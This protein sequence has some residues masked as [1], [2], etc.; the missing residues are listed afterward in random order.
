MRLTGIVSTGCYGRDN[1]DKGRHD[2]NHRRRTF[3]L[4]GSV[5]LAGAIVFSPVFTSQAAA[6]SLTAVDAGALSTPAQVSNYGGTHSAAAVPMHSATSHVTQPGSSEYRRGYRK[7]FREGRGD[8]W[9]DGK[10]LCRWEGHRSRHYSA[11]DGDYDRGYSDG[12][13]RGFELGFKL[14]LKRYC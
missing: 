3:T 7:G 9:V 13:E 6:S 4:S 8:G 5:L 11:P 2:Q 14:A 10:R 1:D 12:Y